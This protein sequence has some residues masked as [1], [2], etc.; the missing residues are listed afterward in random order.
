MAEPEYYPDQHF[1]RK[2]TIAVRLPVEEIVTAWV[3][4]N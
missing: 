1:R 2:F 3:R 4:A